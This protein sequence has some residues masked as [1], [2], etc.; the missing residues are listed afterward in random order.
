MGEIGDLGDGSYQETEAFF[1][2]I[3]KF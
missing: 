1:K 2:L 3:G